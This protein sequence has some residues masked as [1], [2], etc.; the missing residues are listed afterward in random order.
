MR[1]AQEPVVAGQG[2]AHG[3]GVLLPEPGAALDVGE[4]ERDGARGRLAHG[5]Q[6]VARS[7]ESCWTRRLTIGAANEG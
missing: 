1:L 3:V 6:F 5:R 4:Q 7:R 2:G